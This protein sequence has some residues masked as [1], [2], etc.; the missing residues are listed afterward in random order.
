MEWWSAGLAHARQTSC[1]RPSS[2]ATSARSCRTDTFCGVQA[3]EWVG[4][5]RRR[6]SAASLT[7]GVSKGGRLLL[8][9]RVLVDAD[10]LLRGGRP[11]E[12]L[13]R[14]LRAQIDDVLRTVEPSRDGPAN[15]VVEREPGWFPELEAG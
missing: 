3:S 6:G 12:A 1:A 2:A 11:V 4:L 15:A 9:Q 10:V 5:Y 13:R 14:R 8:P 7:L